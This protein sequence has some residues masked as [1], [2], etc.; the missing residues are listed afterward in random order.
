MVLVHVSEAPT[1]RESSHFL[2]KLRFLAPFNE[3]HTVPVEHIVVMGAPGPLIAEYAEK[4][5]T[6]LVVLGSP[7]NELTEQ[8]FATSTVLQVVSRVKCP[9]LCLPNVKASSPAELLQEVA[10]L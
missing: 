5:A 2:E 9:V 3:S 1:S 8:D 7:E 4:F 10:G 6:D